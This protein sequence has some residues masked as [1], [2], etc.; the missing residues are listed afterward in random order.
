MV[1]VEKRLWILPVCLVGVI[2]ALGTARAQDDPYRAL[3]D[4]VS[5][6]LYAGADVAVVFDSTDV[7]VEDSGLSHVTSHR[8]LK[9]L[10]W[11]GARRL[12]A[13]RFDYDPASNVFEPRKVVVHRADGTVEPVDVAAALDHPQPQ[14]MIYWGARMKVLELPRLNPGDAVEMETYKKGFQ[15]AYLEEML[16]DEGDER[17]IPPMRGHYY[18][19]VTFQEN[20]PLREK[21]YTMRISRNKPAQYSVYNGEVFSSLT[22]DDTLLVYTFWKREVPA[23]KGEPRQPDHTD[24]VPKVVLATVKD[25][26]EKSRWFF[27]VN[28]TVFAADDAIRA[29]ARDIV[30]GLKDEDAQ[31]AAVLHWTAQNI[32]YSGISMGKGEGYT[33]HPGTMTFQD[34]AGVCKDIA[35]MS[36]TLLRALGF[37]VYPTMT[38]AGARVEKIPADQFNHC[39]VAVKRQDGT[40]T[41]IDPTWAP[42]AMAVWS[43]AEG[44]Q[45]IVVGSPEGEDLDAIRTFTADENQ[46]HVDLKGE[47]N[48]AGDLEGAITI[49]GT[50]YGDTRLR[51]IL[52]YTSARDRGRLLSGWLANIAP[53]AE[54]VKASWTTLDD[55]SKPLVLTLN[56]RAPGYALQAGDR[57]LLS[58]AAVQFA[59]ANA[60]AFQMVNDLKAEE[61]HSELMV[62]NSRV[63]RFTE[64]LRLP[65]GYR[66]TESPEDKDQ[67]G[68]TAGCEISTALKKGVLT[69]SLEYRINQ[70]TIPASGYDQVKGAY[71]TLKEFAGQTWSLKKG[72]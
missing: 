21:V 17:Y 34:R 65:K 15:I 1:N 23:F 3:L 39:V 29:A 16:Q 4:E 22:L 46:T 19:V 31:I 11:G 12:T 5:G 67:G 63:V 18:D 50:G 10:T 69:S 44:E 61:R 62:W 32:R 26:Q 64:S 20:D 49:T 14:R 71:D 37:T 2:L 33:L 60:R 57:L 68:E 7:R 45:H 66:F 28:D 6:G 48:A 42:Y 56:F 59:F 70:R 13:L 43:R 38:M 36:I 72:S 8:L 58:P 41:M 47:V 25:W 51:R 40:Y 9:V 24:I 55:F 35:G 27:Q 30:R 53:D 52:A 54:V